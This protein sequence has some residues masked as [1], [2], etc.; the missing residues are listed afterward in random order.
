MATAS[1]RVDGLSEGS[2]TMKALPSRSSVIA[3]TDS[4]VLYNGTSRGMFGQ[5]MD[6]RRVQHVH[7]CVTCYFVSLPV[8]SMEDQTADMEDQT[9][10]P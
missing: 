5:R 10:R 3:G 4:A 6:G 8:S 7:H 1:E 2:T 9:P